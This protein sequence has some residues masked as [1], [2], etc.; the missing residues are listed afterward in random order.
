MSYTALFIGNFL[1]CHRGGASEVQSL[2]SDENEIV[3]DK[4]QN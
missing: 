4:Q 3:H 1:K 2:Y